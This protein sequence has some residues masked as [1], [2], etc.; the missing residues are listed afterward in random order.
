MGGQLLVACVPTEGLVRS[1]CADSDGEA[2]DC[3][4]MPDLIPRARQ[5]IAGVRLWILDRQFCDLSQP[6][7]LAQDGDHFVNRFH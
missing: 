7:L 1:F 3:K 4:L 6:R 2:N 5:V